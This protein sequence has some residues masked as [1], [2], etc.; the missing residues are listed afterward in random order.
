MNTADLN[1]DRRPSKT[2]ELRRGGRVKNEKN[3]EV[4]K[5]MK[6]WSSIERHVGGPVTLVLLSP[7][8]LGQNKRAFWFQPHT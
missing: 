2:S 5:G 3:A 6:S 4:G 1:E 7:A 8:P